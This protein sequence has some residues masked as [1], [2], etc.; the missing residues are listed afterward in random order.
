[1]FYV[2]HCAIIILLLLH[3]TCK[4][5]WQ[6]DCLYSDHWHACTHCVS[7]NVPPLV[8]YN[9]NT[10]ERI[11]IY[12]SRNVTDKVSNQKT[13][14]CATSNN[15]CFCTTWQNGETRKSHFFTQM[16]YQCV[17]RIQPVAPWFLRFFD[18]WVI[19]TLLCD[20]LN[21]VI[22]AFSAELL[23][24]A[25]FRRKEVESAAAVGLCCMHNACAP[26]SDG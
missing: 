4:Q 2:V 7:K 8:C 16:L 15:V 1:M 10:C 24:G 23:G 11:L 6:C 25:W 13:L 12:F 5:C 9:F 20:S 26:I 19:L 18:S 3:V 17:A 22:N 14:Y 21:L